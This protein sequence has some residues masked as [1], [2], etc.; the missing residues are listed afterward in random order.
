MKKETLMHKKTFCDLLPW[1]ELYV[2]NI[3]ISPDKK[4]P[5]YWLLI[6]NKIL[7]R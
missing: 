6:E 5:L 2:W 7:R 3:Y 4:S 1:T